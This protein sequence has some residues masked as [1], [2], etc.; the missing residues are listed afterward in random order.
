MLLQVEAL[1]NWG[2]MGKGKLSR[3]MGEGHF[4]AGGKP[5]RPARFMEQRVMWLEDGIQCDK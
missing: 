3:E 4:R 2:L 5:H 1:K